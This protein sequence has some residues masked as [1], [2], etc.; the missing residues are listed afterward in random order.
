MGW[1]KRIFGLDE[2]GRDADF[3][4]IDTEG[5]LLVFQPFDAPAPG[6]PAHPHFRT[7]AG[8]FEDARAGAFGG[9]ASGAARAFLPAQPVST[10]ARFAGRK[11][12]LREVIRAIEDQQLHVI[13]YGDRGIGKTSLLMVVSELAQQATYA[14]HYVS[15]CEDSDFCEIFR[16]IL[17]RIPLLY[18]ASLDPGMEAV[19]Q[20][21]MLSDKLPAGKFSVPLLSE[22]LSS[23]AGAK[24]LIV[25]D[26]F[27]RAA[28]PRFRKS[29]AELIKNLSDRALPVQFLIGGVASSLPGLISDAPS[30]RRNV[31]GVSLPNMNGEEIRDLV[32]IGAKRGKLTFAERA[33]VRL[34]E[35]SAGLPYLAGLLAQYGTLEAVAEGQNEISLRHMARAIANARRE[36]ASRLSPSAQRVF[37][38]PELC[39]H[40]TLVLAAANEAVHN[41]GMIRDPALTAELAKDLGPVGRLFERLPDDPWQG[42][43]FEEDG[44]SNLAWL[45]SVREPVA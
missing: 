12:V 17:S 14:V 39:G 32:A 41:G 27:D 5:E 26:E 16:S 40:K 35:A 22:V 44:A 9:D 28:D 29:V 24:V 34:V 21:G 6:A 31:V 3:G 7:M 23:L 1:L 13:V 8:P 2:R 30:I 42:W 4:A 37:G 43:R 36:I 33:L 19:E 18:D 11:D 45:M 10:I 20:G 38:D 25:L 15:C